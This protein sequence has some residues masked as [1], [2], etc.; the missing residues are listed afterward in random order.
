MGY[1]ITFRPR[2]KWLADR[3]LD[4]C[5]KQVRPLSS[6]LAGT[7]GV[8][9]VRGPLPASEL[10]YCQRPGHIGFDYGPGCIEREWCYK[11]LGWMT[12]KVGVRKGG[13]PCY[14]Y[15]NT[16]W[17]LLWPDRYDALGQYTQKRSIPGRLFDIISGMHKVY[18]KLDA[19]IR[20]IDCLW[21]SVIV[22]LEQEN[23]QCQ[24]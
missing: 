7:N 6:I 10:S 15:D 22:G 19:E 13:C 21:N 8:C 4:F 18:K 23:N 5:D 16:D 3:M 20:R 12:V 17:I 2:T 9:D 24:K 11:L 14:L 1:T